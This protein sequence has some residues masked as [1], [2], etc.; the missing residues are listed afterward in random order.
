MTTIT[1]VPVGESIVIYQRESKRIYITDVTGSLLSE[2]DKFVFSVRAG[3]K[4]AFPYIL[5]KDILYGETGFTLTSE[6]T[7]AILADTYYWDLWRVKA[8]GTR[9]IM[10]KATP[11]IILGAI[12]AGAK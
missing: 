6:E 11:F 2:G 9:E 4:P 7:E 5:Q 8:D 1:T 12:Y 3:T 10:I